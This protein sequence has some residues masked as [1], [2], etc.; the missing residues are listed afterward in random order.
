VVATKE[1]NVGGTVIAA[2]VIGDSVKKLPF[3][4]SDRSA[5][6]TELIL[7]TLPANQNF[8]GVGSVAHRPSASLGSLDIKAA[9]VLNA[10]NR[11]GYNLDV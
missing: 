5:V 7:V 4:A 1:G 10:Q 3:S 2:V 11:Y 8:V 9:V 6:S